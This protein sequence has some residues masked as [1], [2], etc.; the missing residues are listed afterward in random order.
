MLLLGALW[1]KWLWNSVFFFFFVAVVVGL[2][3]D[4]EPTKE[5]N[6]QHSINI[7][8]ATS[9]TTLTELVG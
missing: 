6:S 3:T 5:V 9:D 7:T 1:D 2:K 8:H 4:H